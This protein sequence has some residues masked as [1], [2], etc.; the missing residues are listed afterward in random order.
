[1]PVTHSK[2]LIFAEHV[3]EHRIARRMQ[4]HPCVLILRRGRRKKYSVLSHPSCFPQIVFDQ[5]STEAS[6]FIYFRLCVAEMQQPDTSRKEKHER[7]DSDKRSA[8]GG[9]AVAGRVVDSVGTSG[10]IVSQ[11]IDSRAQ[12]WRSL[13]GIRH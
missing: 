13:E 4:N 9:R 7:A 12:Q 6:A 8:A 1:L 11:C 3:K 5:R 10:E 2:D